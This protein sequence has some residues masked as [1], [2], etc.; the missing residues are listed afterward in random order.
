M[1]NFPLERVLHS[2]LLS[3]SLQPNEGMHLRFE[4][5]VPDSVQETRPVDM[6]FYFRS[7]FGN[8]PL[9]DAYERLL[10]DALAGDASLF[11]R[12]DE[13]EQAWRLIDPIVAAWA[14]PQAPPLSFY[15]AGTWG[16]AEADAFMARDGRQ[17]R[18]TFGAA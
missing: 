3:I 9:P 2:N 7:S 17:W 10:L 15:E 12:S 16:P 6:E 13:I 14:S 18:S 5:K 1:F 11:T 4:A 8:G